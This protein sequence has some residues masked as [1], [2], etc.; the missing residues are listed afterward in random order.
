MSLKDVRISIQKCNFL[1]DCQKQKVIDD[2]YG[3]P[4]VP[5]DEESFDE[6]IELIDCVFLKLFDISVNDLSP[7]ETVMLKQAIKEFRS[8]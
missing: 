6:L 2:I 7:S 4:D 8:G 3:D 1:L 5:S